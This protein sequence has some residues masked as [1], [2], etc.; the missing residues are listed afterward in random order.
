[1]LQ[2]TVKDDNSLQLKNDFRTLIIA[3]GKPVTTKKTV[4]TFQK[5]KMFIIL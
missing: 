1:M 3:I 2:T 4:T 5:T